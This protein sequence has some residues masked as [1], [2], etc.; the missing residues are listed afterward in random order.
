MPSIDMYLMWTAEAVLGLVVGLAIPVLYRMRKVRTE[1][2]IKLWML[3]TSGLV[4]YFVVLFGLNAF[5]TGLLI[6]LILVQLF[7]AFTLYRANIYI[8]KL[9]PVDTLYGDLRA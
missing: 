7:I 4:L 9:Q 6:F 5:S 1:R 2:F 3:V 8:R